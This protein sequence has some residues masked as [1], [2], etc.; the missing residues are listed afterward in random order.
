MKI[1]YFGYCFKSPNNERK[2]LFDMRNFLSAY[3]RLDNAEFKNTFMHHD[4]HVYLL[5]HVS[6]TYLFIITRSH[7]LIRR[8]NTENLS[9][10]E[11]HSL[12]AENEQLGFAS[13][14]IIK[15]SYFGFG[16]TL[17]APKVDVF[18]MYLNNL[19]ECLGIVEWRFVP[20]AL[21]Y[22]ATKAEALEMSFIGKTTIELSKENSFVQDM[23]ASISANTT[24]TID[25]EGIEIIIKPKLRK[26]IK[27]TVNKFLDHIPDNGVQKM[28]M[29]AK[30]E[31]LS[32]MT[33]LYLVGRGAISDSVDRSHES[34]IAM[35]ME[36]KLERNMFLTQ[37]V[38]E[39]VSDEEFEE[40]PLNAI[41]RY[42]NDAAWADFISNIH[43]NN[44]VEP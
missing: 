9:V 19:L 18:G 13:Y 3:S 14:V 36:D 32:Q 34:R 15:E 39:Y 16:S 24:D 41:V 33:D 4:E 43:Q 2:V 7:E 40:D 1:N 11:I 38:T 25:L 37:K 42:Y 22:Q 17:L 6:D 23:L 30:G 20:Q 35:H 29:K 10:G 28:I 8:V 21:L 12:L 27:E 44:R 5:H 31:G 26:N